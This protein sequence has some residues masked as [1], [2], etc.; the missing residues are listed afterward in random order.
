[1]GVSRAEVVDKNFV[2]FVRSYELKE[3]KLT[4]TSILKETCLQLFESQ[5]VSRHLDLQSR[6]LKLRGQ[7]F[8]TIGSC[9]HEGNV[10]LGHLL[11]PTDPSLLHYR[12]GALMAER[13]RHD[14]SSNFIY[15]TLLSICASKEDPAS[16]GR[17]K[18]WGSKKLWV[19]PQTSTI[20]SHLPKSVGMALAIERAKRLKLDIA[21]PSDSIVCCSFGD[22]SVNHSTAAGAFNA[23]SWTA[24]QNLGLPILFVCEDN[25]LGISV[26]TPKHWIREN[27]SNRPGIS[28]VFADGLNLVDAFQR[29]QQAIETCRKHRKPVF[30]HMQ[31]VRLLGHAGSDVE[32]EYLN[33]ED[34]KTME[35]QDPLLQ[36][37]SMVMDASFLKPKEVLELY[38]NIRSKVEFEAAKAIERPRLSSVSEIVEPL[39]PFDAKKVSEEARRVVDSS[40]RI[41]FFNH[42]LPENSPKPRHMAMLINWALKDL[43]L[44]YPES[45]LFGEDVAKKGGVYHVTAGLEQAFGVGRVFNTLLDEQTILGLGIG[46]GQM[47]YLPI[48]EIQYLAYYHNAE[49]QIRGEAG[50]LSYFSNGQFKNPMVI[51]VASFAYQKGFGGHFHNDNSIGALR[52]IPGITIACPSRGDDAVGMLRTAMAMAKVNGNLVF[53]LEPIARY[54]TKDLYEEGDAKW[55]FDYPNLDAAVGFGEARVYEKDAKDL[56]IMSYGNG[57]Y[58]SLRA[59]KELKEKHDVHARIVDLRWLSP[60]PEFAI[61]SHALATEKVLIVDECRRSGGGVSEAL[62]AIIHGA[63]GEK[64]KIRRITAEDV[65]V[66]LG[67]AANAV[68]PSEEGIVKAALQL[69]S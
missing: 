58:L 22:A 63:K 34:I 59:A 17:H 44:K 46:F 48:P 50:S 16:G 7:S 31:T 47:G 30:L 10:V 2:E 52:D 54:M 42:Q 27:F 61:R 64:I 32:I 21:V 12:S 36:T 3:G 68:L 37:A 13:Y 62:M 53:F 4:L 41:K 15:D 5:M 40:L 66:P 1:M 38:E 18:V 9:G 65:Y 19:P 60:L 56:C 33:L 28:Y 67:S 35:V 8:Y 23:A 39:A 11:R 25:G 69:S 24:F 45:I 14:A 43:L 29:T 57:V 55:C 26:R 49:D 20:A 51:R 6:K